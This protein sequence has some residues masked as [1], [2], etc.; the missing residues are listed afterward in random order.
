MPEAAA[1]GRPAV[2]VPE[3]A[4]RS[5]QTAWLLVAFYALAFVDG[6][7][8][9][10]ATGPARSD[11]LLSVALGAVLAW[12]AVGDARARG[13][14]IPITAQPWFFLGYGL[15]VPAYLIWSRRWSGVGWLVLHTAL[16]FFASVAAMV[17]VGLA[18]FGA[19]WFHR[20]GT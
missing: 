12:W 2:P 6:A 11:L 5:H 20:L 18:V 3:G 9:A 16:W 14:P 19:G 13:R 7:K 4:R 17:A 10:A 15:L 8:Q 1:T